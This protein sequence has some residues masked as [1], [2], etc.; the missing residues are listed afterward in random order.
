MTANDLERQIDIN[1]S[2]EAVWSIIS[3]LRRMGEWSP[4]ARRMIVRGG[5]VHLGTKTFNINHKGLLHW[6]TTSVVTAFDPGKY[7]A[8]H[9]PVNR[10]TWS[11][12]IEPTD[13]GV[14]LIERRDVP[15]GTSFISRALI[16][17][18]MGGN[19]QFETDL[20]AGMDQT[21]ARV[22]AEAEAAT[23]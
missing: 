1:A 4:Q 10:T 3:D 18:F 19:E 11:Y 6:T 9:V 2:P 14:R 23:H 7:L 13:T 20:R 22:K 5:P 15:N 12:R 16:V 21:L 8:F 17:A